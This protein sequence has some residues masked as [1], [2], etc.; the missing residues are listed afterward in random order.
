ML[1]FGFQV[2]EGEDRM[3]VLSMELEEE[4]HARSGFIRNR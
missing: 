3:L 1:R 4:N 2:Q